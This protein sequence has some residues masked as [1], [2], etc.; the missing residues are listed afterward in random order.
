MRPSG[1][2][3]LAYAVVLVL[4]ALVAVVIPATGALTVPRLPVAFGEIREGHVVE[5]VRDEL[6]SSQRGDVRTQIVLVDVEATWRVEESRFRSKSANSWLLGETLT[7][8]LCN[9]AP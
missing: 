7:H 1:P 4:V 8:S 9:A 2:E 3:I 5:I 6:Q